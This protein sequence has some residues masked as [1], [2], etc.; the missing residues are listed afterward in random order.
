MI[1]TGVLAAAGGSG[2][3]AGAALLVR[4]LR[5]ARVDPVAAIRRLSAPIRP[6]AD[7]SDQALG[8]LTDL[9]PVRALARGALITIPHK[10][11]HL[12]GMS[13]EGYVAYRLAT[14]FVGLLVGP[15]L[16]VLALLAGV[17]VPLQA[18]AGFSVILG[19][20]LWSTSAGDVAAKATTARR[21]A[22]YHLLAWLDAIALEINTGSAPLQ[23]TEDA[24]DAL[25]QAWSMRRITRVLL[26]AQMGSRAP[27]T[28]LE[29]LGRATGLIALTEA[30]GI[31]RACEAEGAGAHARLI[32]R[33]E[34][35]RAHLA[36]EEAA[37]ANTASQR[38]VLPMTFLVFLFMVLV[39]YPLVI[40]IH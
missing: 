8:R 34:A 39:G 15:A 36:A 6:P 18:P 17:S 5:P 31:L 32:A 2:A 21:E 16:T 23:A 33:A 20:L 4:A 9:G 14:V 27:W 13:P 40:R 7:H 12:V 11:L 28:S 3:G 22:N 38:M 10:D 30:A 25:D 24:A 26:D 1:T 29:D 37:A 35:L 19:A